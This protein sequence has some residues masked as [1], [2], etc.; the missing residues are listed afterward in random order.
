MNFIIDGAIEDEV[1]L[2]LDLLK[3][4]QLENHI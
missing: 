2:C 1:V 3:M 4:A